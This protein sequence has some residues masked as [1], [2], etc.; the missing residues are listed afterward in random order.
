MKNTI[1]QQ[2]ISR[3]FD[4]V[5]FGIFCRLGNKRWV[6]A[7]IFGLSWLFSGIML[8]N[9]YSHLVFVLKAHHKAY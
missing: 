3:A 9:L 2:A 8:F 5:K 1:K 7:V 4:G 6:Y